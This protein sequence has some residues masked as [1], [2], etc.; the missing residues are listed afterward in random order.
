MGA[1]PWPS[2]WISSRQSR[3]TEGRLI[4]NACTPDLPPQM[5]SF[6]N[7]RLTIWMQILGACAF[8]PSRIHVKDAKM[9]TLG[10]RRQRIRD[11]RL[12]AIV[13]EEHFVSLQLIP[14][15]SSLTS[16]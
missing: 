8:T 6:V 2:P 1:A 4:W 10:Q 13:Q 14:R 3:I 16:S 15:H 5:S 7:W 12:A 11:G 9:K